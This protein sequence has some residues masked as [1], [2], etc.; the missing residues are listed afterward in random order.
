MGCEFLKYTACARTVCTLR[1]LPM[2]LI[3][4]KLLYRG[5]SSRHSLRRPEEPIV[6]HRDSHAPMLTSDTQVQLGQNSV[7]LLTSTSST[8]SSTDLNTSAIAARR[9][10]PPVNAADESLFNTVLSDSYIYMYHVLHRICYQTVPY[11]L[12]SRSHNLTL[13]CK[14]TFYDDCNFMSRMIF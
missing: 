13:T 14:S 6:T 9:H 10:H 2:Y 5:H 12:R 4:T 11:N 8:D 1:S 7:P 3:L